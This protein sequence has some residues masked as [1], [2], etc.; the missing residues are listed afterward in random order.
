MFVGAAT[1]WALAE[2]LASARTA[3][4]MPPDVSP[5]CAILFIASTTCFELGQHPAATTALLPVSARTF[6]QDS[7]R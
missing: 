1:G 2:K 5:I 7:L 4:I 6:K 3:A